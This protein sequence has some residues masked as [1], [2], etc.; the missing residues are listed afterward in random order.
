MHVIK[1][2]DTRT[3]RSDGGRVFG[4]QLFSEFLEIN[5]I[6]DE[7]PHGFAFLPPKSTSVSLTDPGYS[8]RELKTCGGLTSWLE[9]DG[10]C[11]TRSSVRAGQCV[12]RMRVLAPLNPILAW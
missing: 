11:R 8:I 12:A 6:A 10:T 1:L 4:L 9:I 3:Q 7:L 2:P 5:P